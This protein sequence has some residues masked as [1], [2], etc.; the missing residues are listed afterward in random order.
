MNTTQQTEAPKAQRLQSLD[1]LRGFDMLFIMGGESFFLCLGAL[2]PGTLFEEW[3][4]QMRHV[5]WNGFA[6]YDLIF[7]LF[8]FIAGISFPFSMSKSM[9]DGASKGRISMK[10]VRR[11][12]TLI[13]L[14]AVYNG[15][16]SLDFE[17]VRYASVLGR[18][19]SAWMLAALMYL[20]IPKKAFIA[21]C[22]TILLAYWGIL[23]GI[24]APDYPDASPFSLEGNI[25]GY[26]D[27]MLLP[28]SMHLGIF[29][30]EGLL[31]SL[32]AICTAMMGILTGD[33]IR[34]KYLNGHGKSLALLAT[35]AAL[36]ALGW[37]WDLVLPV[38]KNLW[39]SSFVCV[40]GGM[41]AMLF[42]I[43]YWIVDVKQYRKWTLFFRVIGLNSITIYLAQEFLDVQKPIGRIFG[44]VLSMVPENLYAISYWTAYIII[45]WGF[46]YFLYR[47]K[48]FLKV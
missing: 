17:H 40:A 44:G 45:C 43:F 28:G 4:K 46:L 9:A 14:G 21:T 30:P 25:V 18:I 7:P 38:N 15:L 32:P 34:S 1:T 19:G 2:L 23:A 29:D 41:S 26:V 33:F 12:L 24:T 20:W 13:L 42:A 10:I 39:T 27:R 48:I 37:A 11:G 5:Q 47:N 31:S 8:L 6:F 16:L 3:G 36:F 22:I 35:G